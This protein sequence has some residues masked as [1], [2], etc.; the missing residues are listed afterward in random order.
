MAGWLKGLD[1]LLRGRK[2]RP[3]MLTEGTSHIGLARNLVAVMLLGALYGLAMALF[4]VLNRTPPAYEQFAASAVKV[5]LLYLLTL[6]VTFPSLY[7]FGALVGARFSALAALRVVVASAA[8]TLAVLASFAPITVFFTFTTTSYPFIKLLNVLFLA[9][10]GL[11]GISF[12]LRTFNHLDEACD[13]VAEAKEGGAPD[14]ETTPA[15][16]APNR[17]RR[18]PTGSGLPKLW[19]LLY[20]VV[21]IQMGWILRPF[22][23]SPEMP[24]AWFRPRTGNAFADILRTLAELLKP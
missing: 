15:G 10:A 19:A 18:S 14:A 22:I 2:T 17:K 23:G 16:G 24:F 20:A 8:V 6:A 11:I 21:G 5:P 7:V 12:Q 9:L 1:D 4:S 3:E 13:R